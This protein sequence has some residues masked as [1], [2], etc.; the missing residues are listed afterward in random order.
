MKLSA[1]AEW[2]TFGIGIG[3]HKDVWTDHHKYIIYLD[4]LFMSLYLAFWRER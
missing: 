3:I 1:S 4:I 2:G